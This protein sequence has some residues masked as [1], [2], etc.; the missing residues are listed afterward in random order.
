MKPATSEI[1][2]VEQVI[3]VSKAETSVPALFVHAG[4]KASYT[5]V[6]FFTANIRNRNT[7]LAYLRAVSLFADW[8]NN[9]NLELEQL[10][11]VIV[12]AYIEQL[13]QELSAPTVK[14]HLAA[15]KMLFDYLV[16]GQ[17]LPTNPAAAVRGPSHVVKQGK[18]PVLSPTE[19]RQLLDSINLEK[20]A[21][22][23]DRAL[24]G[25]MV[26]SFARVSAV[27]N[28]NVRDYFTKGRRGWF[29]LQEK[30]G[31]PARQTR[32][33]RARA[34]RTGTPEHLLGRF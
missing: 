20:I 21:G 31:R 14:Q 8:C 22:L 34:L 5:F 11:P 28:M 3:Q 19:T 24:I 2:R 7:R 26:F 6:E 17:V 30:G 23:R 15:I 4:E 25:V 13:T 18:T 9:R 10:T 12:A 27:T 33:E 16:I 32:S 1:I 29:R